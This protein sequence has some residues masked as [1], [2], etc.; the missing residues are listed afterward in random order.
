MYAFPVKHKLGAK[1]MDVTKAKKIIAREWLIFLVAIPI[2]IIFSVFMYFTNSQSSFSYG[3]SRLFDRLFSR[4]HW[5]NTLFSILSPYL[6]FQLFRSIY[7][8]VKRLKTK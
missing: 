7:Y 2:G 5:F 4:W 6:V 8:S 1:K 3:L